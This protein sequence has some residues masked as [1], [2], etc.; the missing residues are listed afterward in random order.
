MFMKSVAIKVYGQKNWKLA[1]PVLPAESVKIVSG[2]ALV[3]IKA[4]KWMKFVSIFNIFEHK[5]AV[6]CLPKR[7]PQKYSRW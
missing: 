4:Q 6:L 3:T 7:C 5:P 2:L 1:V